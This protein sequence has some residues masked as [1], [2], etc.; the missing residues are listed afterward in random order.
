MSKI[1]K[2]LTT[3]V[4]VSLR[5]LRHFNAGHTGSKPSSPTACQGWVQD[6]IEPRFS[7]TPD[8][9]IARFRDKMRGLDPLPQTQSTAFSTLGHIPQ[10]QSHLPINRLF[11]LNS[12]NPNSA[13][14]IRNVHTSPASP[15]F[16]TATNILSPHLD[17]FD[18]NQRFEK[19]L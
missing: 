2:E 19:N 7:R 10:A 16:P 12:L 18:P 5:L 9:L 1:C 4:I 14:P 8:A 13:L 15:Q 3:Q 11:N 6:W 17:K